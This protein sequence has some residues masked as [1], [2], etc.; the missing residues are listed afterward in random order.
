[1]GENNKKTSREIYG[2]GIG[3]AVCAQARGR[4]DRFRCA[5]MGWSRSAKTRTAFLVSLPHHLIRRFCRG[6]YYPLRGGGCGAEA[7]ADE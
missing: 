3:E 7:V 6:G 5:R 2:P 1:M 4:M